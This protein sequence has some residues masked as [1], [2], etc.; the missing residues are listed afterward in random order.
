MLRRE[1]IKTGILGVTG[2]TLAL[3]LLTQE[4]K[5]LK[6]YSGP[7]I[8]LIRFG[9]GVRRRE[10]IDAGGSYAPYFLNKMLPKGVLYNNMEMSNL[11][12]VNTS[13]GQG[14]LYI[15][16]G[17]YG[18]FKDIN[19]KFF[20]ER[21]E[22]Q[23]PTIFEYLR[24]NYDVPQHRAL[25]IN[26]E[27]RTDEE[28]FNF[29]SHA[30]YGKDYRC[31]TLS[32]YRYKIFLLSQE[33]ATGKLSEKALKE[34]TKKLS[35]LVNLD[36]RLKGGYEA[37]THMESFWGKWQGHYGKNGLVNPRGD[38]LLTEI[39]L[40]AMRELKP[41]M[42]MVNYND[43][44]YV[45][46]GVKHHYT[47]GIAIIDKGIEQIVREVERNEFYKDNTVY[48]VVPDCGRDNNRFRP[49]PYQHHFGDKTAHEIFALFA[50][51]GVDKN[52]IIKKQSDQISIA[53]TIAQLMGV[54][55][56]HAEGEILQEVFV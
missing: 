27:N 46:W 2:C 20:G 24:K 23:V 14:T 49:V 21:F 44:D 51:K 17:K 32:L 40:W 5:K 35:K 50:G 56:K 15:M 41:Q 37:N 36:P 10:T 34:K 33:I 52:K 42:L 9:G 25:I 4:K 16:T 53:A 48:V 30:D 43:P 28:F 31:Q 3:P 6:A 39:T 54:K 19:D 29:S 1:F 38:R 22:A 18:A 55:A 11:K 7:N 47:R 26:G 45:H 13:H 12:E 8:V